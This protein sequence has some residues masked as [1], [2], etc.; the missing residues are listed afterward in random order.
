[1]PPDTDRPCAE[2]QQLP[3]PA[4]GPFGAWEHEHG[5]HDHQ[6]LLESRGQ[7]VSGGLVGV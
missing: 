7:E 4:A 3:T 2:S 6:G 1:V 5:P